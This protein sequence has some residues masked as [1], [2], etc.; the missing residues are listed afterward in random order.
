MERMLKLNEVLQ[1]T[2]AGRTSFWRWRRAGQFPPPRKLPNGTIAWLE[3]EVVEWL[4]NR[5]VADG[6]PDKAA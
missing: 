3:S 4:R 2:S 6:G 5:P 1:R